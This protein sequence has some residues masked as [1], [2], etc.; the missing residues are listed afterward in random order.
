[1]RRRFWI[2][3]GEPVLP[4]EPFK[5]NEPFPHEIGEIWQKRRQEKAWAAGLMQF[6][7]NRECE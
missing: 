4:H 1:M 6:V 5:S 2:I 3:E 7:M